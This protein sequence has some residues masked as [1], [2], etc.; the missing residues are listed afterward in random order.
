MYLYISVLSVPGPV[1]NE[2]TAWKIKI[3]ESESTYLTF[4]LRNDPSPP[5]YLNYIEIPPAATLEYLCRVALG[6]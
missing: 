4:T 1:R 6:Q 3:N 5:V 2:C